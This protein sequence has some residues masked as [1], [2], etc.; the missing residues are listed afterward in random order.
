MTKHFH[1]LLRPRL[2]VVYRSP[3]HDRYS[4]R[5]RRRP[6]TERRKGDDVSGPS[7]PAPTNCIGTSQQ[8]KTLWDCNCR[9]TEYFFRFGFVKVKSRLQ[10]TIGHRTNG[11]GTQAQFFAPWPWKTTSEAGIS[12]SWELLRPP[13]VLLLSGHREVA[14]TPPCTT[15]TAR[16]A[17]GGG[18]V[19]RRRR[20]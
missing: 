5:S 7:L 3:T 20:E 12:R 15:R 19:P 4:H 1:F 14:H 6:K 16:A 17:S 8:T 11:T 10:R 13:L 2:P 18:G 9:T